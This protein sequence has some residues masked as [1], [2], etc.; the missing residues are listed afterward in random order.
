MAKHRPDSNHTEPTEKFIRLV[1]VTK[2]ND[3]LPAWQPEILEIQGNKVVSRKLVG[4]RDVWVM[5]FALAQE[6]IDPRNK[7]NE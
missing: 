3:M 7:E 5:A 2:D 6:L 4:T 1:E